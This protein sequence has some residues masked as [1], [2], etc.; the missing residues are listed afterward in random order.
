MVNKDALAI[1][2]GPDWDHVQSLV[3]ELTKWGFWNCL[4][5]ENMRPIVE[6]LQSTQS[7]EEIANQIQIKRIQNAV[8]WIFEIDFKPP[9]LE[10]T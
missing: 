1:H 3:Q 9:N 2:Y 8:L 4:R 7:V 5:D 6:S 10:R